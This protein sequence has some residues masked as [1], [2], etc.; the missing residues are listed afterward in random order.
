MKIEDAQ[1]I[2]VIGCPGAGK[3]TF[4]RALRDHSGLPLYYLD[5][6]FHRSDRTTVTPEEFD[7][8]L[9]E[10][11]SRE[12][13]IIDGNYQRTLE[14][15]LKECEAVFFLD[16]PLDVCL[17]GARSRIGKVRED[18]PWIEPEFDP[19]F[20]QYIMD[21]PKEQLPRMY[22]LLDQYQNDK[23]IT[24]FHSRSEINLWMKEHF[25]E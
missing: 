24:V 21:F 16:L 10:I 9:R 8:A 11:I 25:G 3:S 1:K 18:L 6:I 20:Q 2:L 23:I 7:T 12:R 15:R 19:E 13:W 22:R 14:M 4:S 17:E 5:R